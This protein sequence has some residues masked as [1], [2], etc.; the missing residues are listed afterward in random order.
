MKARSHMGFVT[1][2]DI[3]RRSHPIHRVEIWG[4]R[5]AI[6]LQCLVLYQ[7][8]RW[9]FTTIEVARNISKNKTGKSIKLKGIPLIL[10]RFR[11]CVKA[12]DQ[13]FKELTKLI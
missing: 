6:S 13:L 11:A 3:K 5:I 9:E 10:V 4:D 8:K 7:R 2:D 1:S 12:V